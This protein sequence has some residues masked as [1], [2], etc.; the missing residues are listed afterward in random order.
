MVSVSNDA[1][2]VFHDS[3]YTELHG[4]GAVNDEPKRHAVEG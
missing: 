4:T 2:E 3:G 1:K